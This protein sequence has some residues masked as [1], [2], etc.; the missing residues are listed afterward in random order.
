[1]HKSEFQSQIRYLLITITNQKFTHSQSNT[2]S[3]I[4]YIKYHKLETRRKYQT[5]KGEWQ[6]SDSHMWWVWWP[7]T[8]SQNTLICMRWGRYD[9]VNND[10]HKS[11]LQGGG[12]DW[13]SSGKHRSCVQ[14]GRRETRRS[15]QRETNRK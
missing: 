5:Q 14:G 7:P 3:Q 1:M 15:E 10:E 8:K 12:R 4:K 13:V 2:K 6:I 11:C 9:E